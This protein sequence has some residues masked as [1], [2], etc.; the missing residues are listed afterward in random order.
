MVGILSIVT[1]CKKKIYIF[2]LIFSLKALKLC[3]L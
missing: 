1:T 2:E 3:D